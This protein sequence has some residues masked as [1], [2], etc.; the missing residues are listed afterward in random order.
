M[1]AGVLKTGKGGDAG[2][3]HHRPRNQ[4]ACWIE[5]FEASLMMLR[6]PTLLDPVLH[7]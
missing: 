3:R 7:T 4:R 1:Y 5:R 6:S 2:E